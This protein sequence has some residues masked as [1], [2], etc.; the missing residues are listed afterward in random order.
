MLISFGD[1][2]LFSLLVKG[3]ADELFF[4]SCFQDKKKEKTKE[5]KEKDE[6]KMDKDK[7]ED[8]E[9]KEEEEDKDDKVGCNWSVDSH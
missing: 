6:K 8:E 9:K 5:N 4:N 7:K 2:W 3:A 1:I